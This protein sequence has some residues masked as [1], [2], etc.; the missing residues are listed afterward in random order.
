[1]IPDCSN[2]A[3]GE[4]TL[5]TSLRGIVDCA[6]EV[7][8]LDHAVHSGKYGGPVPDAVT[9][10]CRLISTLHD[11]AGTVAVEGLHTGPPHAVPMK[12]ARLRQVTGMR[13]G[14]RLLGEGALSQQM[15]ASPAVAVLGIDAPPVAGAAHQIIPWARAGISVRLAP[16]DNA[17]RAFQ[18]V[19]D[20]LLR[21]APWNAEVTV[22]RDHQSQP[23]LVDASG[24]AFDAFRRACVGTWGRVPVEAGSGG[25]LPLIGAL[26]EA[27]PDM[28]LLLTGVDDPESKAHAENESVHLGE[29]QKCCVNEAL[30]LGYLAAQKS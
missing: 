11:A 2:W 18:A 13:P 4:P 20:H 27:Y 17:E 12:P 29:L 25:S 5:I 16:G 6:V 21:H 26:A 22:T 8:T 1:V 30:L 15:W 28:A 14:V 23:H 10:L 19:K 7:R 3:I 24:P 9:A